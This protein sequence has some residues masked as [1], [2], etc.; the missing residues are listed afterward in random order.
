MRLP[1]FLII[2]AMKAGTSSLY[3]DLSSHPQVFRAESKEPDSLCRDDVLSTS[4]L[5]AYGE[6]YRRAREDQ[7]IVDASTGY[8]KRPD[9][10]A[11]V[12][13]AVKVLPVGFKVIYI[14]RHPIRR[15][16]SQHHHENTAG[17]VGPCIDEEVRRHPRF[18]NYSRYAFQL[19]PW[20]ETVGRD[21]I[22]VIKFEDYVDRR[23]DVLKNLCQ[24][25][26]LDH[27]QLAIEEDKAYNK[28][29]GK[30]VRNRFWD[31]VFHSP[32]YRRV[33]R[34]ALSPRF[35]LSLMSW[36]LPK[37]SLRPADPTPETIAWLRE[38]LEED[39]TKLQSLLEYDMPLWEDFVS[40]S[41]SGACSLLAT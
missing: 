29:E 33:F 25:L 20:L 37:G 34:R 28:T 1:N 12:K 16:V 22:Q 23:D 26:G 4:G 17:L 15:I 35:R 24:F 6:L 31:V 41:D 7:L 32:V 11:V 36:L 3:M 39:M 40:P 9:Y 5:R 19:E 10:E 18:I 38:N 2:G 27:K 8:S 21:R 30:P 13:R 14:V